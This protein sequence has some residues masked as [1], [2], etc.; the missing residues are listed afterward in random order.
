MLVVNQG[1]FYILE[2]NWSSIYCGLGNSLDRQ[3]SRPVFMIM[4]D[5]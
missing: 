2:S 4:G 5:L 3:D 1:A